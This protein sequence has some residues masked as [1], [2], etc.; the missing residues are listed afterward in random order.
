MPTMK[1]LSSHLALF[2]NFF[3]TCDITLH[4]NVSNLYFLKT[5]LGVIIKICLQVCILLL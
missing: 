2:F 3:V 4:K 5:L 1:Y